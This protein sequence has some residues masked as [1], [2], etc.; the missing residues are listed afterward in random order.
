MW[1]IFG[2][3]ENIFHRKEFF[4]NELCDARG[5]L[6]GNGCAAD[7]ALIAS[8]MEPTAQ[9]PHVVE[10]V[11]ELAELSD[12]VTIRVLARAPFETHRDII[13]VCRRFHSLLRS[14]A[15]RDVRLE[16]GHAEHGVVVAGGLLAD[17]STASGCYLLPLSASGVWRPIASLSGARK[18]ACSAILANLEDNSQPEMWALGGWCDGNDLATV[19]AWNPRT[20]VWR[21][22]PPLS[23]TCSSASAGVVGGCLVVA[24]GYA[25]GR[26]MRLA[27]AC[28][29]IGSG[30]VPP[31]P[32][33]TSSAASCVLHGRLYVIGGWENTRVYP[34]ARSLHLHLP[35]SKFPAP[36]VPIIG[37]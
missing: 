15:F 17:G 28:V 31:L 33:A 22:C 1:N 20:N 4:A 10:S 34:A 26:C 23:R 8:P 37:S 36:R 21:E 30:P 19:E 2:I 14:P 29:P 3:L 16:S 6:R 27:E 35:S 18:L 25:D 24:G 5:R 9:S 13:A 7:F 12:E 32:Y 11:P